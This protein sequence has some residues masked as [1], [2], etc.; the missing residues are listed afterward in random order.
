MDTII[1][2]NTLRRLLPGSETIDHAT[3]TKAT[4]IYNVKDGHTTAV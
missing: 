2:L 4:A 1:N 3:G